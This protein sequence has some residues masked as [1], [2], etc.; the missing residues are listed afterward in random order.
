MTIGGITATNITKVGCD[1]NNGFEVWYADVPTGTSADVAMVFT[2]AGTYDTTCT[3]FAVYDGAAGTPAFADSQ[4]DPQTDSTIDCG[5][6]GVIMACS[7]LQSDG[8]S[9]TTSTMT[10]T[11]LTEL[12]DRTNNH[13]AAG[14]AFAAAQ[15]N[16]A[17]TADRSIAFPGDSGLLIV[18]MD[19]G[20]GTTTGD[21]TLVSS[22]FTALAV[23]TDCFVTIW[24]ADVAAIT[25][26]TDLT[27][28]VSLDGGTTWTVV[29]LAE[30]ATL[31]TGRILT[32]SAVISAQPSGTS[33][34]YRIKTLNTK[35]QRIHGVALQ[36]S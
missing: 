11:G 16:L 36:W 5:A 4:L 6:G 7:Y 8:L 17:V 12:D 33:M 34:K 23:P 31:T 13:S 30:S 24:Q 15:T 10:W 28:E 27:A 35:E 9:D 19:S 22:A 14:D 2:G 32:G 29:T 18:S 3:L 1:T 25:L 26:N 20:G 21:M